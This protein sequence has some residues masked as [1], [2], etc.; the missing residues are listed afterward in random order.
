MDFSFII[1]SS[2]SKPKVLS[3][4]YSATLLLYAPSRSKSS[5]GAAYSKLILLLQCRQ[6]RGANWLV[7][8][9]NQ[10]LEESFSFI[11]SQL[12]VHPAN[13]TVMRN[14]GE[15]PIEADS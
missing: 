8:M 4:N 5:S 11:A 10:L 7:I 2:E 12:L 6:L 3:I 14:D 15:M 9:F 1:C 13:N